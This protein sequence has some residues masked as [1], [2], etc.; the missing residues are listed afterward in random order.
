MRPRP[1]A[2]G[3][4]L[5]TLGQ[6]VPT[7]AEPIMPDTR[8]TEVTVYADRAG[9]HRVAEG[10]LLTPGRNPILFTDLPP[11]I[12]PSSVRASGSADDAV[13]ILNVDVRREILEAFE[14]SDLAPLREELDEIRTQIREREARKLG[15]EAGK[16]FL[17]SIRAHEAEEAGQLAAT[18]GADPDKLRQTLQFLTDS[19]GENRRE[20]AEVVR[21]LEEL[22]RRERNLAAEIG[23]RTAPRS[24]RSWNVTVELEADTATSVDLALDYST[25]GA[26]WQPEY[27]VIVSDALDEIEVVYA[28]SV[29]QQTGEDWSDV[30]ITLSTAQPSLGATVPTLAPWWLRF[31]RIRRI[32]SSGRWRTWRSWSPRRFAR[33]N[34][35]SCP[36]PRPSCGAGAVRKSSR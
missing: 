3:V 14:D 19:V 32:R 12:D 21:K 10:L 6:A 1:L 20:F 7:A 28:A 36:S 2:L 30:A 31:S 8:I 11:G 35:S 34:P 16:D 5:C 33:R 24:D 9:V 15:L 4:A 23:R 27:D 26:K 22:R 13:R 18:D 17:T 25:R 29:S